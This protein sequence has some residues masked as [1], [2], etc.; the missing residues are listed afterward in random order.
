MA[1]DLGC[2]SMLLSNSTGIGCNRMPWLWVDLLGHQ[3]RH[4]GCTGLDPS[5]IAL[6]TDRA[7]PVQC[8]VARRRGESG[9]HAWEGSHG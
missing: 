2:A 4:S 9:L 6:L 3:P 8:D 1:M 7:L 5:S